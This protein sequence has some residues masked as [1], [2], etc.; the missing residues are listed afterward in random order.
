MDEK[1]IKRIECFHEKHNNELRSTPA[2]T[3]EIE[4]IEEKLEIKL[5]TE[6]RQFIER[7]G[8]SYA[9]LDIHAFTNAA[10]MGRETVVDLTNWCREGYK[11]HEFSQELNESLVFSSDGGGNPIVI[12][13]NGEVLIYYHDSGEKEVLAKSFNEFIKNN[14]VEW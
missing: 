12:N 14:F 13:S 7:F 6:Y 9:G 10:T 8:G 2:T 5:N 1:L 11:N 3:K 4:E